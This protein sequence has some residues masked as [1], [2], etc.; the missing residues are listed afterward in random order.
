MLKFERAFFKH[1]LVITTL[2]FFSICCDISPRECHRTSVIKV[3][4]G[5]G[6]GLV[7]TGNN[8]FREQMLT[9]NA[10]IWR[11]MASLGSSELTNTWGQWFGFVKM[12]SY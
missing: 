1:I 10:C 11:I 8:P 7:P 9:Q 6:N 3:N 2:D 4:I 5:S 12:F